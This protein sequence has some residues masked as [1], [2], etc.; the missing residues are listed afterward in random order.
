MSGGS[1]ALAK[2]FFPQ[3]GSDDYKAIDKGRNAE[4]KNFHS[5][6]PLLDACFRIPDVKMLNVKQE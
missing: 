3:C 1:P 6:I 2:R 4:N 5:I